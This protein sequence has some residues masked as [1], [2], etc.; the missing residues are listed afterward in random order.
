MRKQLGQVTQ[1]DSRCR[2]T[3]PG[4]ESLRYQIPI[5]WQ[6]SDQQPHIDGPI[7]IPLEVMRHVVEEKVGNKVMLLETQDFA[8]PDVDGLG[9]SE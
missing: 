1:I 4:T 5:K 6:L 8:T 9:P 3:S 2:H 7:Q